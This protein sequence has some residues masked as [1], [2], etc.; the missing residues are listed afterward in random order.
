MC[1]LAL[2][3]EGE[4]GDGGRCKA[5]GTVMYFYLGWQSKEEILDK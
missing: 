2:V 1:F 4:R 5:I 3:L